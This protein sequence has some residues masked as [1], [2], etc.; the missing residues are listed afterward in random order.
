MRPPPH[1][2]GRAS[3]SMSISRCSRF[4]APDIGWVL[5]TGPRPS[6]FH[7]VQ[8]LSPGRREKCRFRTARSRSQK[9]HMR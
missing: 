1:H 4:A 5:P 3:V 7:D 9:N 2:R 8:R 6:R